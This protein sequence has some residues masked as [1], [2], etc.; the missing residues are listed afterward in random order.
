MNT[1]E[2]SQAPIL[3]ES[4]ADYV[5]RLRFGLGLN[6]KELAAKADIHLQSLGKMERGQ[7]AKLNHKTRNGLAYALGVPAEYLEAECKGLPV[8][9]SAT[10]KF[11]PSCWVPGTA[12]D[13]LWM[14]IRAKY[15]FACATELRSRCVGCDEPILSLRHRFCPC[16]GIAYKTIKG[17]KAEILKPIP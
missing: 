16:C 4:L 5:R 11:C 9:L 1:L 3:G 6:Q 10:L 2:Q 15:C 12:P 17:T 8:E 13:S 7:T 14:H